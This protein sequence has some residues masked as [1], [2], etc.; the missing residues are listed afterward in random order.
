MLWESSAVA[1]TENL[2]RLY[3]AA[4]DWRNKNA[5]FRVLWI[6]RCSQLACE[7]ESWGKCHSFHTFQEVPFLEQRNLAKRASPQARV[8]SDG[9]ELESAS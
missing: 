8:L 7:L 4:V 6:C 9:G 2:P 5:D 3:V 1:E